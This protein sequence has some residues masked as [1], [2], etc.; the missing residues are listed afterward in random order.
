[1]G[2]SKQDPELGEFDFL[3][4]D[5]AR[6]GVDPAP[7][8]RVDVLPDLSALQWRNGKPRL[9]L[10]HGAGL[11]AHSWDSIAL[12]SPE[13]VIALDL[14]GHGH[15]QW[16]SDGVYSAPAISPTVTA[17]IERYGR[18]HALAGHSLGA[19]VA[20]LVASALP[21]Q[22]KHLILVDATPGFRKREQNTGPANTFMSQASFDSREEIIQSALDHGLGRNRDALV[23]GVFLNTRVREDGRVEFRHH[24]ARLSPDSHRN[25]DPELL[26]EP[27]AALAGQVLLVR[28]TRGILDAGH[29]EEF[30][31]KVPNG[32]VVEL[33]ASH[34]I[35]RDDPRGLAGA[36]E[37]FLRQ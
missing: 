6:L 27:L 17:A 21:N 28:A 13:A 5:A 24:L 36:I 10:L 8:R 26:W 2:G 14:P 1:M 12:L 15:S 23:R 20:I 33:E 31:E 29:V 4:D 7:V 16:R 35:Y 18:V 34:N 25:H 11:H 30:R 22:I 32:S 9:A 3:V 19:L 37:Q